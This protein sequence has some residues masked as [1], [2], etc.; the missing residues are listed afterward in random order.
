MKI[1]VIGASSQVGLEFIDL[2]LEKE[3]IKLN[4]FLRNSKK[5]SHLTLPQETVE[6]FEGSASNKDDLLSAVKGVDAVF[7]SLAGDMPVFAQAIVD[8]MKEQGVK[9][10]VFVTTL[11][12]L[13]EVKGA[14]GKWNTAVIG[15]YFPVYRAA[16]DII[17]ASGL[18]YTVLRPAW[19]TNQAE[20]DYEITLRDEDFKGTEV[21]RR[22]VAAAGLDAI[23]N[24]NY[25]KENIGVNK[26]NTDADKPRFM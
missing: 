7:V 5:L 15:E 14:F 22:S 25:L 2:A 12:I 8:A 4:L 16:S 19:L 17:E 26:P 1:A 20:V 24:E 3:T 13:D 21:S 11:G 23:V 10:I 6:V 18:D 9:R